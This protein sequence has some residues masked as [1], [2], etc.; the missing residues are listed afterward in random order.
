[1]KRK[2]LTFVFLCA[3]IITLSGVKPAQAQSF[4]SI[5][6]T[7]EMI[8]ICMALEILYGPGVCSVQ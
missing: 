2:F 4:P 6:S 1:M 8:E 5:D 3:T 7:R